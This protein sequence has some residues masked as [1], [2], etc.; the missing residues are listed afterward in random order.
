L[1]WLQADPPPPLELVLQPDGTPALSAAFPQGTATTTDLLTFTFP[2]VPEVPTWPARLH[3]G[4]RAEAVERV[5]MACARD[6]AAAQAE[7]TRFRE[8]ARVVAARAAQAA[9]DAAAVA[10]AAAVAQG[11]RTSGPSPG[12]KRASQPQ[13]V[14]EDDGE[15]ATKRASTGGT[16][17]AKTEG[18]REGRPPL[19][20]PAPG[21]SPAALSPDP[22]ALPRPSSRLLEAAG[23]V[24]PAPTPASG[25]GESVGQTEE[26]AAAPE[27][28]VVEEEG[29]PPAAAPSPT[30]R[31]GVVAAAAVPAAG[32]GRR[33]A[34]ARGP[35]IVGKR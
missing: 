24:A 5:T 16:A 18:G 13:Q 26:E 10:A 4:E 29:K 31:G 3:G 1:A 23:V 15:P 12:Q 17:T 35:K 22:A 6:G 32:P 25:G 11:L 19:P 8:K 30:A 7:A 21:A 27:V 33:R 28:L 9:A 2:P 20:P 14:G 34:V